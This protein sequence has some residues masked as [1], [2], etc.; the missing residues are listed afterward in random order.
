MT[1]NATNIKCQIC[2]KENVSLLYGMHKDFDRT[3]KMCRE[4]WE[5]AYTKNRLVGDSGSCAPGCSCGT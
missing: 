5:D 2:G 3:V 4:C 1:L